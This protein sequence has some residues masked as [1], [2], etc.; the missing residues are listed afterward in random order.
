[1]KMQRP[2]VGRREVRRDEVIIVECIYRPS[3]ENQPRNFARSCRVAVLI[4]RDAQ[5][6]NAV[7]SAT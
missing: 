4:P 2:K 1:V 3:I 6:Q 5:L 7:N